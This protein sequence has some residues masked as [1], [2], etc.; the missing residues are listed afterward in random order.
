MIDDIEIYRSAKV[1]V[2]SRGP[3]GARERATE[4][5][6]TMVARRDVEGIAVWRL[7]LKAIDDIERTEPESRERMN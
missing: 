1:L 2:D 3:D 7:I 5:M 6:Q 4:N